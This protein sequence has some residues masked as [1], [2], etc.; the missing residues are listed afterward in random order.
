LVNLI[1]KDCFSLFSSVINFFSI[2]IN[3]GYLGGA[4]ETLTSQIECIGLFGVLS[5]IPVN[6]KT[7]QMLFNVVWSFF[8]WFR[9]RSQS[10]IW[11]FLN[12]TS[13]FQSCNLQLITFPKCYFASNSI[14]KSLRYHQKNVEKRL[15]LENKSN[16]KSV[17]KP[18]FF[19]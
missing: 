7:V 3:L 8:F 18:W 16:K 6:V 13:K 9:L 14:N 11:N 4:V 19:W 15:F 2:S 12:F 17:R 5:L 10:L 1:H